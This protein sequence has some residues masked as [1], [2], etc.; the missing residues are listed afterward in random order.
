LKTRPW[1]LLQALLD[2]RLVALRPNLPRAGFFYSYRRQSDGIVKFYPR[3][4][5]DPHHGEARAKT[6]PILFASA[7]SVTWPPVWRGL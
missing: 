3:F 6:R 1:R 5:R 2:G 7:V 4:F